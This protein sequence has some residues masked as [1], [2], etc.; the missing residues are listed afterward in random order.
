MNTRNLKLAEEL[1]PG[2]E[3]IVEKTGQYFHSVF[4]SQSI[5]EIPFPVKMEFVGQVNPNE[6]TSNERR[7]IFYSKC[8]AY[9]MFGTTNDYAY[10]LS[11]LP[12]LT[13][14]LKVGDKIGSRRYGEVVVTEINEGFMYP[15]FI[16]AGNVKDSR[17]RYG[18][19]VTGDKYPDLCP[20][21]PGAP[22]SFNEKKKEWKPVEWEKVL[23]S[24]DGN[25]WKE[26]L[27]IW[28]NLDG[29][30]HC[31][32]NKGD[33]YEIF[34]YIKFLP[35]I[36][37]KILM[38]DD[39]KDWDYGYFRYDCNGYYYCAYYPDSDSSYPFKYAKPLNL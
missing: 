20:T 31:V 1:V 5:E 34:E 19:I 2:K 24:K 9:V 16:R 25:R 15:I 4:V 37:D 23:A 6:Y 13:K 8:N 26:R 12:D 30:Y 18:K 11:E 35:E 10:E 36:G 7:N 22:E 39:G 14:I 28:E 3:Y 17:D 32:K 33:G 27:F 38:S 21:D 29:D